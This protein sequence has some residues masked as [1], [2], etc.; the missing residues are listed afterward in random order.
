MT[1]PAHAF[2]GGLRAEKRGAQIHVEQR[3]PLNGRRARKWRAREAGRAVDEDVEPAEVAS[4]ADDQTPRGGGVAKVRP[5]ADRDRAAPS[6]LAHRLSRI[7]AGTVIRDRDIEAGVG[8]AQGNR[9]T[10]AYGAAGH[11][12]AAARLGIDAP[13]VIFGLMKNWLKA[14]LIAGFFVTV[15]AVA[16]S[17]I[18]YAFW[19]WIDDR[20]APIY[21]RILGRPVPGLGFLTAVVLMLLMGI[22]AR[23]VAGRRVLAFGDRWLHRVPVFRLLYP[24]VKMLIDSFS[25]ERRSSFKAVVL[26][27]HPRE[28]TYAFGFVTSQVLLEAPAG[29]GE[30][31]TVFVPS[32]NLYLG[33]IIVVPDQD[34]IHTGLSVEEGIRIILSAGT[35]TPPR[36]PRI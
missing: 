6:Q 24:S 30:M 10:D 35:A 16:T 27:Q 19:S 29:K 7:G 1:A 18:L 26:V 4:R 9:A 21:A 31:V 15:P 23:N 33:D 22:V 36:L 14:R 8:E 12:R 20:F 3:V 2:G 5:Y 17:W 11:E 25:P 13:H 28:G 32:N 34:V